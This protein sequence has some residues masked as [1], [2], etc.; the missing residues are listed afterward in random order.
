MF[1]W[2]NINAGDEVTI[3]YR[4]NAFG[5][6][7]WECRCGSP[8]CSGVVVNSFFVLDPERQRAYL[9]Y[10]PMFIRKEFRRRLSCDVRLSMGSESLTRMNRYI[11]DMRVS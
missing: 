1:A 3:D 11:L 5:G 4:L 6:E 2:R 10:A 7:Q 8:N 9:P